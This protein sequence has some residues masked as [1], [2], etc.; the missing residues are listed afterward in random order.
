MAVAGRRNDPTAKLL[1]FGLDP[2]AVRCE[3]RLDKCLVTFRNTASDHL[4]FEIDAAAD[5]SEEKGF[6]F[7]HRADILPQRRLKSSPE[8]VNGLGAG[9]NTYAMCC[10]AARL[11][12]F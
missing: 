7:G 4:V 10:V 5:I 11:I 6:E 1:Q 12:Q 8:S 2:L 9:L 3:N